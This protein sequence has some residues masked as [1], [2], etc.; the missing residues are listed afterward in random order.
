MMRNE[1]PGLQRTFRLAGVSKKTFLKIGFRRA[2]PQK[3]QREA[4]KST[5]V[6]YKSFALLVLLCGLAKPK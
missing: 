3:P 5:K 4:Q 1:I 6:F 2:L